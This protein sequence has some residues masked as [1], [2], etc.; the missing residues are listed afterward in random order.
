MLQQRLLGLLGLGASLGSIQELSDLAGRQLG[1]DEHGEAPSDLLPTVCSVGWWRLRTSEGQLRLYGAESATLHIGVILEE[2]ELVDAVDGRGRKGEHAGCCLE[3]EPVAHAPL[4]HV[5]SER[6]LYPARH[7]QDFAKFHGDSVRRS[8]P[9]RMPERPRGIAMAV[10]GTLAAS[11][12]SLFVRLLS[13]SSSWTILALRAVPYVLVLSVALGIRWR[14]LRTKGLRHGGGLDGCA[15]LMALL[16]AGQSAAVVIALALTS[17]TNSMLII[18]STPLLCSCV[19]RFVLNEPI[20]PRKLAL[21]LLGSTGVAIVILSSGHDDRSS[22]LAGSGAA[23]LNPLCWAAI[24]TIKRKQ[25][26]HSTGD[27]GIR[28]MS[29]LLASGAMCAAI[30]ICVLSFEMEDPARVTPL[31]AMLYVA[32]GG[33]SLPLSQHLLSEAARCT[34]T[35]EVAAVKTAE[36]VTGPA[37]VFLFASHT[38]EAPGGATLMGGALVVLAVMGF[39][40]DGAREPFTS[41]R[42]KDTEL[43]SKPMAVADSAAAPDARMEDRCEV[44]I[45]PHHPLNV[46]LEASSQAPSYEAPSNSHTKLGS[47]N[48]R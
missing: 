20:A 19:D 9:R 26:A 38:E 11:P 4:F 46:N 7:H 13:H 48:E 33:L 35:A 24:W 30:G 8:V 3:D 16:M 18:N 14:M 5:P 12:S 22:S 44:S 42:V 43:P 45:E 15:L 6:K 47:S 36:V 28:A 2:C 39:A 40:A 32:Y 23:L 31:D 34:R 27:S 37:L 41:S 25:P 1:V 10:A 21:T 17:V 29:M